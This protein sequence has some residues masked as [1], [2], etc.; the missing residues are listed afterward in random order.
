VNKHVYFACYLKKTTKTTIVKT[1]QINYA[2]IYSNNER[3]KMM[4]LVRV[5]LTLACDMC[6]FCRGFED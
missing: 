5:S 1:K 6:S 3:K 4:K 2:E